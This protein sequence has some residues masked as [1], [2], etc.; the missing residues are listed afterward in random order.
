MKKKKSFD[1]VELQD[2]AALTI[3]AITGKMTI[4]EEV[5]YW[6]KRGRQL[7]KKRKPTTSSGKK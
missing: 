4:E 3:Y 1:C 6:R 5:A 2:K 7:R